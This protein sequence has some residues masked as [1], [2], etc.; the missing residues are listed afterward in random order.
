MRLC[1]WSR[2]YEKVVLL[3]L[4]LANGKVEGYNLQK[5]KP[6]AQEFFS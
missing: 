1:A 6:G 4:L 5:Q 2:M 3:R